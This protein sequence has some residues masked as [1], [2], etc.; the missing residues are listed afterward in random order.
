MRCFACA[1]F[2][3]L[4]PLFKVRWP[5]K[6]VLSRE[7]EMLQNLEHR[8]VALPYAWDTLRETFQQ[9]GEW[10]QAYQDAVEARR[11][12]ERRRD[13]EEAKRQSVRAAAADAAMKD[14]GGLLDRL[15]AALPNWS[16]PSSPIG[17][18]SQ[19]VTLYEKKRRK[20]FSIVEHA[21]FCEA[22]GLYSSAAHLAG[23][24]FICLH[25]PLAELELALMLFAQHECQKE[26]FLPMSPPEM[27]YKEISDA[28][29]FAP[30]L[31]PD[32][33]AQPSQQYMIAGSAEERRRCLTATAEVPLT[34]YHANSVL[35]SASLPRLY[36]GHGHA[37]RTEAGAKGAQNKGL[38]RLHQFSKVE[39]VALT[40][41]ES[42][43]TILQKMLQTSRAILDKLD[44][45]Y[46][47]DV[48][49]SFSCRVFGIIHWHAGYW[50]CRLRNW[51]RAHIANTILKH[52]CLVGQSM[53]R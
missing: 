45:D 47:Y 33:G 20:P 5:V 23:S 37:F 26:G 13:G 50:I 8:K 53:A 29:G 39:M 38:Y 41:P 52:G 15:M 10:Q 42:A 1:R 19:A 21:A 16:H 40:T 18:E 44:L 34:A 49:G 9:H 25:G 32:G 27:V 14:T 43:P 48:F 2:P 4:P 36:V 35:D 51:A 22:R 6:E 31:D 24:Q 7:A 12:A 17:P 28:C 30:R 11:A 3:A 46:R